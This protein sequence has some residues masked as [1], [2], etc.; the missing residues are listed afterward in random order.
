MVTGD[1]I[2]ST[3]WSWVQHE[4]EVEGSSETG[5]TRVVLMR[6]NVPASEPGKNVVAV[7]KDQR[8]DKAYFAT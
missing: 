8:V 7:V 3:N 4:S 2:K 5:L 6:D 1:H